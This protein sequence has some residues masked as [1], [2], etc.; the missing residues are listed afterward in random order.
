MANHPLT[1]EYSR[2]GT[3]DELG[4]RN[5]EQVNGLITEIA[6]TQHKR[7]TGCSTIA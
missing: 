1:A 6:E 4:L 7:G 5:L 2:F 3:F